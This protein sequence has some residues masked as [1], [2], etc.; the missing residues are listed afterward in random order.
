MRVVYFEVDLF[1]WPQKGSTIGLAQHITS[2]AIIV[3]TLTLAVMACAVTALVFAI[4]LHS[5][6]SDLRS[7]YEGDHLCV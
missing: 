1:C 4:Q 2:K 5:A 7:N 3:V 6:V